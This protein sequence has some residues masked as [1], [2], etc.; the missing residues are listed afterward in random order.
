MDFVRSMV[1]EVLHRLLSMLLFIKLISFAIVEGHKVLIWLFNLMDT[2]LLLQGLSKRWQILQFF[3]FAVSFLIFGIDFLHELLSF[4]SHLY[5]RCLH[6]LFFQYLSFGVASLSVSTLRG[7]LV[8][9]VLVAICIRVFTILLILLYLFLQIL[10]ILF[11]MLLMVNVVGQLCAIEVDATSRLEVKLWL[12]CVLLVLLEQ[13]TYL[14]LALVLLLLLIFANILGFEV[15]HGMCCFTQSLS[16]VLCQRLGRSTW[17]YLWWKARYRNRL[18]D[19]IPDILKRGKWDWSSLG[20]ILDEHWLRLMT[21]ILTILEVCWSTDSTKSSNQHLRRRYVGMIQ[22][23]ALVGRR[24]PWPAWIL[25]FRI[26]HIRLLDSILHPVKGLYRWGSIAVLLYVFLA[27]L[28]Q[29]FRLCQLRIFGF[30]DLLL[31]WCFGLFLFDLLR[32]PILPLNDFFQLLNLH[33]CLFQLVFGPPPRLLLILQLLGSVNHFTLPMLP[34]L[35]NLLSE[36]LYLSGNFLTCILIPFFKLIEQLFAQ[37]LIS[38]VLILQ[39]LFFFL[40]SPDLFFINTLLLESL[41][42]F[43]IFLFLCLQLKAQRLHRSR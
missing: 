7:C 43:W 40:Q 14:Q 6:D 3:K 27:F 11:L 19:L 4:I 12:A 39:L 29:E 33:L 23:L 21:N 26:R 18:V 20:R 41:L 1:R 38:L 9:C 2:F 5:L 34:I 30:F 42:Y 10:R 16:I 15:D 24:I 13:H 37:L 31:W 25:R 36:L 35:L 17:L 32:L 28:N 8:N 22:R